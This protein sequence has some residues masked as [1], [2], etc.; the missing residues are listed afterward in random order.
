MPHAARRQEAE[1]RQGVLLAAR[2]AP[3]GLG[4]ARAR[5]GPRGTH[6]C[7]EILCSNSPERVGLFV[8]EK[9]KEKRQRRKGE[10]FKT[11][12]HC[13]LGGPE[14]QSDGMALVFA[15]RFVQLRLLAT[16]ELRKKAD[17][18]KPASRH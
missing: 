17:L 8:V 15:S 6:C 14:P 16:E 12:P 11:R 2:R 7:S 1:Q 9:A 4:L 10:D 3:L 13:L 18:E 5:Q